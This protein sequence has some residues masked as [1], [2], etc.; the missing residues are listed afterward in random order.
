VRKTLFARPSVFEQ[1]LRAL[2]TLRGFAFWTLVHEGDEIGQGDGREPLY[3]A[4][5]L[6]AIG[7]GRNRATTDDAGDSCGDGAGR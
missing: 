4:K 1:A 2:P 5:E 6:R 7:Q 3:M